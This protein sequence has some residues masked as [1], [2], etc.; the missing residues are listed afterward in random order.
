M[1]IMVLGATGF[2]GPAVV[3]RLTAMGHQAVAVSR[4]GGPEA[5]GVQALS[6]DRNDAAAVARL[7][8][9]RRLDGV[10]DL[11]GFT[12]ANTAP[13]LAALSG[14][15]GRY[16]LA[17]SGDVYAQYDGLHRKGAA[18]P[19]PILD[20]AAPLRARL[21]PYRAAPRRPAADPQ[22]WMDDYDKIPIERAALA[23]EGLEA[24]VVRLPMVF[25]PRDRQRRFAWAIAPMLAGEAVIEVDAGWAAWR[26]S[27][28]FVDDVA[29]GLALAAAHPGGSTTWARWKRRITSSGRGGSP[30]RSAGA[31]SCGR[32]PV[33]AS[34]EPCAPPSTGSTS[35]IRWSPTPGASGRSWL[36]PRSWRRRRPWREPSPTRP[37]A[38]RELSPARRSAYLCRGPRAPNRQADA[39]IA[40]SRLFPSPKR[41][42]MLVGSAPRL[43]GRLTA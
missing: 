13:L 8:A 19:L 16:V 18:P 28:G 29:Q 39:P 43:R 35:P 20:E 36:T 31:A 38:R 7:A 3:A 37:P 15:V 34:A 1:R 30:A 40:A 2:I 14:R 22:A 26:T 4:G 23:A 21:H 33:S 42:V 6:A 41:Q 24:C 11:L 17:S 10:I 9:E 25:G 32:S 27:Y 5:A 12:I